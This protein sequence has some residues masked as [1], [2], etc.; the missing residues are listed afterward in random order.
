MRSSRIPHG[1]RI[2]GRR[3]AALRGLHGARR[4]AVRTSLGCEEASGVARALLVGLF[5]ADTALSA[6]GSWRLS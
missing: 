3:V 6:G 1:S 5:V 2:V 4:V